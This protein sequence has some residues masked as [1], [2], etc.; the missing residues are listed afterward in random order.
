MNILVLIAGTNEPSN[1]HALASAFTQGIHQL[2]N[3]HVDRKR[4]KDFKI[5]HFTLDCYEE[6]CTQ[7]ED[8]CT[9]RELVEKADGIVIATPIWNFS[10]PAHLKNFIDHIGSFALDKTRSQGTLNGKPFYLI[11]TGGAPAAAWIGLMKKT[12]SSIPEALKYFGG[13][14][15][16]THFEGKCI[17]GKGEFGLVVDERPKSLAHMREEGLRFAQTVEAYAKTGKLPIKQAMVKK[18]YHLGQRAMKK[19]S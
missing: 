7:E 4:L 17:K 9:L 14:I 16:G 15:A 6:H 11:F 5:E 3:V 18:M 8:F 12:T 1:S 13:T 2:G 10:V 19:F